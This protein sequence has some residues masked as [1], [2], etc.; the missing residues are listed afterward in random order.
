MLYLGYRLFG[1][2]VQCHTHI[3]VYTLTA[4]RQFSLDH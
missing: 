2:K 1:S 3:Q 4:D